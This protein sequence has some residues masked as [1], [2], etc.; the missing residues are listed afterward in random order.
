MV[1]LPKPRSST[2]SPLANVSVI[3]A[4]IVRII[5]EA[6]CLIDLNPLKVFCLSSTILLQLKMFPES[7]SIIPLDLF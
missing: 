6:V 3:G 4:R 5:D 2:F 1:K 7:L